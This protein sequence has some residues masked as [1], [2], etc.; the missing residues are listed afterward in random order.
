MPDLPGCT[1]LDTLLRVALRI[2]CGLMFIGGSLITE[3][4][5][6]SVNHKT[7][8]MFFYILVCMIMLIPAAVAAIFAIATQALPLALGMGLICVINVG[9]AALA[10]FLC[11]NMLND[12]A[13]R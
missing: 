1:P 4:V 3:R 7:Y 12:G 8:V 10:V 13:A 2:S 9:V 5:F 11:R 6:G